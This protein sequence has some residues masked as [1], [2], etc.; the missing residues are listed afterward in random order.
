M[1]IR[2]YVF[3]LTSNSDRLLGKGRWRSGSDEYPLEPRLIELHR[4]AAFAADSWNYPFAMQLIQSATD[5]K[6]LYRIHLRF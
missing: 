6:A 5:M 4:D 3:A 2:R 1:R